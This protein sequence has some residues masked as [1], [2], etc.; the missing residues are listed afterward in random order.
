MRSKSTSDAS[1]PLNR[2]RLL[3]GLVA[4]AAAVGIIGYFWSQDGGSPGQSGG[5]GTTAALMEPGPLPEM[6]LG[7]PDAPVT[8]I[9]YSSLTCPH[10]ANFHNTVLPQIKD[11]YVETGKAR[12]IIREFPLDDLATAAFMIARCAGPERYFPLIEVMYAKQQDWA[13]GEGNPADKLFEIA[14]Q[15]GF[16]RESFNQCL[17]NQELFENINTVR[18]RGAKTFG[19]NS[20]PT[21]FVNGQRL[22]GGR[23]VE[24]F[25]KM[26]PPD[27]VG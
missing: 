2:R 19:V 23:S 10:C 1:G 21:F 27:V 26:M 20:T 4:A 18:E 8:I 3:I 9:E 16:T 12:Y 17:S 13:F 15:A 24:E 6:A 11:K 7:S 14:R 25:E 5:S 22:Q